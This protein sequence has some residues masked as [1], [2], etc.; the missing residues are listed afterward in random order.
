MFQRKALFPVPAILVLLLAA[1]G[2]AASTE[3]TEPQEE[4]GAVTEE[5]DATEAQATETPRVIPSEWMSQ[6]DPL[7]AAP[8]EVSIPSEDGRNLVGL[9]YPSK[10][11]P[12]PIIVLMHQGG[13]SMEDWQAVAPWLQNRSDEISQRNGLARPASQAVPWL[14]PSWFPAIL[15]EAS[16]GVL[17]FDFSCEG[18]QSPCPEG[19]S[20]IEAMSTVAL[21]DA[22]AAVNFASTLDGADPNQIITVGASVHADSAI[23][24]CYLFNQSV[25]EGAAS[26]RCIGALALSP[27]NFLVAEFTVLEAAAALAE[28][29]NLV[30]GLCGEEDTFA[31]PVCEELGQ[32]DTATVP[33]ETFTY[34]GSVHGME[35]I[36]PNVTPMDP[37]TD[38]NALEILLEFL[39]QVTNLPVASP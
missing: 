16:F 28:A 5:S 34:S 37:A 39:E 38:Q 24:G 7:P 26:G 22:W 29:G 25:A 15:P 13:G 36:D 10:V 31:A 19:I 27:S 35:L 9:Y 11:N 14:D 20:G 30:S 12:A 6:F 4:L 17:V 1:C 8:Q 2:G 32:M 21:A 3:E 18:G 33:P 23:D